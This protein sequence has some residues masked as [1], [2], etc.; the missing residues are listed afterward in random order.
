MARVT[1]RRDAL[2]AGGTVIAGLSGA[3]CLSLVGGSNKTKVVVSSKSFPEQFILSYLSLVMLEEHGYKTVDKT[4]L[5][6][7]LVCARALKEGEADHYWE[8]TGT[9]WSSILGHEKEI[10]DPEKLYDKVDTEYNE[11]F[12]IDWLQ[13][14]PFNN[15]YVIMANPEWVKK[16]GVKTLEALG[17]YIS[18]G[19]TDISIAMNPEMRKREDAWGGLPDV[20]GFAEKAAKIEVKIM[21]IGLAYKAVAQGQVQLGFGFATNPKIRKFDLRVLEDTKNFFIIYNPAPNVRNETFDQSMKDLLN[22][23]P[24]LL[25]TET[26]R[27]LN[28]KVIIEG[29]EARTVAKN[30]LKQQGLI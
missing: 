9:A 6:G 8:Y 30:F 5:G 22:Q 24:P 14:A 18:A 20:Y 28:A 21:K 11:K 3:G 19:H 29:K 25:D 26:Q 4:G 7:S 13:R 10:R 15:T 1:T 12:N 2:K 17:Q 23:I 16:T 27:S